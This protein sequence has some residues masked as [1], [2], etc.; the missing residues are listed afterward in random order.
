MCFLSVFTG[1][2]QLRSECDPSV[3]EKESESKVSVRV[4]A[5]GKSLQIGNKIYVLHLQG[6]I[7]SLSKYCTPPEV[8]MNT[9]TQKATI[10]AWF[11]Y[12]LEIKAASGVC[13]RD[14]VVP[15]FIN[16]LVNFS[17]VIN[18]C[19]MTYIRTKM[20]NICRFGF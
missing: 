16:L 8:N 18:Y 3:E 9:S 4:G 11:C 17:L 13:R 15:K 12:L 2:S 10:T 7:I 6:S 20:S 5:P 14:K 19:F 1:L